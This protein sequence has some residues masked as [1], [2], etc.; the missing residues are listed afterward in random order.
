MS[1]AIVNR[2]KR[3]NISNRSKEEPI[4]LRKRNEDQTRKVSHMQKNK[5]TLIKTAVKKTYPTRPSPQGQNELGALSIKNSRH[6]ATLLR[7]TTIYFVTFS[8]GSF[9]LPFKIYLRTMLGL[10]SSLSPIA[11]LGKT[12]LALT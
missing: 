12:T 6:A 7:C 9:L 10:S 8:A 4:E 11:S 3:R 5:V 2:R 1:W